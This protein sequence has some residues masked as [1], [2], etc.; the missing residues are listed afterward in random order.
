MLFVGFEQ[1][2]NKFI[3]VYSPQSPFVGAFCNVGD[4][5]D[6]FGIQS[7]DKL[8]VCLEKEVLIATS[9]PEQ[10]KLVAFSFHIGQKV[11]KLRTLWYG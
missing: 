3:Q 4:V 1:K 9:Y 8:L 6:V 11:I 10:I 7:C 5:L 2:R